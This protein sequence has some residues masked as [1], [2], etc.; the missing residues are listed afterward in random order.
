MP[1]QE[2]IPEV[3]NAPA[4]TSRPTQLARGGRSKARAQRGCAWGHR[5]CEQDG[6]PVEGGEEVAQPISP[7]EVDRPASRMT[8]QEPALIRRYYYVPDYVQL[9]LPGPA[10]QASTRFHSCLPGLLYQRALIAFSSI[11]QGAHCGEALSSLLS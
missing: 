6:D 9:R 2:T 3:Q 1:D 7:F 10:D 4:S 5:A 11:H 8:E